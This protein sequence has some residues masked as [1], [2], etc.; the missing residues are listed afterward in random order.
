MTAPKKKQAEVQPKLNN[1]VALTETNLFLIITISVFFVMYVSAVVFLGGRFT[2]VQYFLDILNVYIATANSRKGRNHEVE[3]RNRVL[4][5][6]P[7][8]RWI[9]KL[10]R[11]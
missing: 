11:K 8:N 1:K 4:V 5:L 2:K 7:H 6:I 10:W 9:G 3:S